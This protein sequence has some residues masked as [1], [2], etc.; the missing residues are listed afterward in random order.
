V[1]DAQRKRVLQ[2][3]AQTLLDTGKPDLG[4][5]VLLISERLEEDQ[6]KKSGRG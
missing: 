4:I 1:S 6:D 2:W 5:S 3:V